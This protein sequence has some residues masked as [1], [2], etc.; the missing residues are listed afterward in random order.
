M[1]FFTWIVRYNSFFKTFV[2]ASR[3]LTGFALGMVAGILLAPD[4]GEETRKKIARKGKELKSKFNDLVDSL[5][6][7]YEDLRED[8][9]EQSAAIL[10]GAPEYAGTNSTNWAG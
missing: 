4:R 8:V 9:E 1:V 5:Q 2:M 7:K 3:L 6:D 10:P